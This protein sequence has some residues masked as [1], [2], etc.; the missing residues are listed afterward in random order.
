MLKFDNT[1][2]VKRL[3]ES[4][5]AE[6]LINTPFGGEA[7]RLEVGDTFKASPIAPYS[8]E[9]VVAERYMQNGFC[10]YLAKAKNSNRPA[11]LTFRNKDI[12]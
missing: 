3:A 5:S 10:Y 8:G 9:F 1:A 6:M 7:Y 2:S 12:Q 4:C 11:S